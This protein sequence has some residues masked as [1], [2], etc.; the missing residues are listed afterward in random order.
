MEEVQTQGETAEIAAPTTETNQEQTQTV[1]HQATESRNSRDWKELRR[2][3]DE[4]ERK[5]R[6]QDEVIARL[7]NQQTPSATQV[8]DPDEEIISSIQKEDYVPG[9][10]VAKGFKSLEKKFEK[11]LQDMEKKYQAQAQTDSYASLRKEW[12][13]LDDVVN[14]ENL[15]LVLETNPRLASVWKN[16]DDYSIAVQAYPYLKNSGL[17]GEPSMDRRAQEVDKKIDS[18]KKAPPPSVPMSENRTMAQAFLMKDP[19][20]E[21]LF[22]EM[23]NAAARVGGSY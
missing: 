8:P 12:K 15:K 22:R 3:K 10:K 20:K 1:A 6:M 4:L 2:V 18:V 19:N 9:E 11:K 16:L 17:L 5:S 21:K 7:M 23:Q 13:D 14:P